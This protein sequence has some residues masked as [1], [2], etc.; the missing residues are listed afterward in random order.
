ML[1]YSYYYKKKSKK[2]Y[3]YLFKNNIYLL[4]TLLTKNI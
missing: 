3:N 4:N 1:Y 2:A